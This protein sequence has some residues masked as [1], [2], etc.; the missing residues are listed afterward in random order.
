MSDIWK[1]CKY[2]E[3][4]GFLTLNKYLLFAGFSNISDFA[5]FWP[6]ALKPGRIA[7][8]YTLFLSIAGFNQLFCI[9][10]EVWLAAIFMNE[11][12]YILHD[13]WYQEHSEQFMYEFS[14]LATY[15]EKR[16]I[17]SYIVYKSIQRLKHFFRIL[18]HQVSFLRSFIHISVLYFI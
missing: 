9:F 17:V 10:P 8:C 6:V 4:P 5:P 2:R 7:T 14:K 3:R 12:V 16:K 11:M 13:M 15:C 1:H 18:F